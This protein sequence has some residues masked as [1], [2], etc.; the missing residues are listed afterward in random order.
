VK[1]AEAISKGLLIAN[2]APVFSMFAMFATRAERR[3]VREN[4]S[5]FLANVS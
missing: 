4:S 2:I 3:I 5:G 1:G